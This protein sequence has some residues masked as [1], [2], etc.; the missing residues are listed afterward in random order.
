MQ[1]Q[2]A[3]VRRNSSMPPKLV[4][5]ADSKDVAAYVAHVAGQPGE[6][7]GELASACSTDV[8]NKE[9]GAKG[10]RVEIDADPSGA[11]SFVPAR[12]P[13]PRERSRW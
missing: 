11:L 5:G 9:V 2:I 8:S 7:T 13:R 12:R 10:G 3:L 6:D 4:T 1:E